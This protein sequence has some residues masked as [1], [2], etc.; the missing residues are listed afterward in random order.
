MRTPDWSRA[1][2]A[3]CMPT[4]APATTWGFAAGAGVSCWRR[5]I[6]TRPF[7]MT[8]A[9]RRPGWHALLTLCLVRPAGRLEGRM[10]GASEETMK[11]SWWAAALRQLSLSSNGVALRDLCSTQGSTLHHP[12]H[13][14][15]AAADSVRIAASSGS[16]ADWVRCRWAALRHACERTLCRT[17]KMLCASLQRPALFSPA[18]C[19]PLLLVLSAVL[20]SAGS[21][22]GPTLP[23]V[24]GDGVCQKGPAGNQ[25]IDH[26][27]M[28]F[29]AK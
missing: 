14:S 29:T 5:Q 25:A 28:T 24:Y 8:P 2:P 23:Q 19:L 21:S 22:G 6:W 3:H 7:Q 11:G 15:C 27:T 16:I 18:L 9:R 26:D 13:P 20:T 1:L 17:K 10:K 4:Q 12:I